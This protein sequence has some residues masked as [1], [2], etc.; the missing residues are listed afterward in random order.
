LPSL[1]FNRLSQHGCSKSPDASTPHNTELVD[2]PTLAAHFNVH[3]RFVRT[4]ARA[5]R[6]PFVRVGRYIRFRLA[7]VERALA[8][9]KP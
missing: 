7:D 1:P 8:E 9:A 2:A 6:I 5:G 4:A 3:Q